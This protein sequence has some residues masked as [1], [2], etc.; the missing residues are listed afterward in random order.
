MRLADQY[1]THAAECVRVAHESK[2]PQ[3]K[4]ML[5]RMAETWKRLAEQVERD[6]NKKP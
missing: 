5:L 3:D 6:E 4:A 2:N 1:R